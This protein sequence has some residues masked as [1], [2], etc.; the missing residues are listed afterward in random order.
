[1]RR[2]RPYV[3]LALTSAIFPVLALSAAQQP[4][5]NAEGPI[6]PN[7]PNIVLILTDDQR[8]DELGEMDVVRSEIADKGVTLSRGF[9]STPNCCPSRASFL[10]GLY[11]QHS[12]VW[13]N[14]EGLNPHYGGY[15]AFQA[16]GNE[17]RTI[18]Y[19]LNQVGY[20][21]GLAG[22][23]LNEMWDN[24]IP[25]GWDSWAA[26]AMDNGRYYNYDLKVEQYVELLFTSST[27]LRS[28]CWSSATRATWS[29]PTRV[30]SRATTRRASSGS[31]GSRSCGSVGTRSTPS[32]APRC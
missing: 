9:V 7:A 25:S 8:A 22:K 12:G 5:K 27:W 32:C 2:G 31:C 3:L 21:T 18:A 24:P 29:G 6:P 30:A 11:S 20:R 17:T 10:T 23:Y 26:F 13:T 19:V 28:I 15:Q 1:M 16:N 14:G 4:G